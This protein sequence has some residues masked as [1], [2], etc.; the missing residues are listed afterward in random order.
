LNNAAQPP[1]DEPADERPREEQLEP[2]REASGAVPAA[3]P[4]GREELPPAG[5]RQA[6][7]VLDVRRRGRARADDGGVDGTARSR[8]EP[9]QREPGRELEAVR[10]DVVVR[11]AVAEEVGER[12]CEERTPARAGGSADGGAGGDVQRDDQ[13]ARF[14]T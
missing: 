14:Q 3:D 13:R 10:A 9:D 6:H 12:S 2:G 1:A 5:P 11:N 8:E 4:V 7:D